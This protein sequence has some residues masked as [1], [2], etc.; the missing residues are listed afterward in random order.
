VFRA[1]WSTYDSDFIG[2]RSS[3]SLDLL[4][5]LLL[6]LAILEVLQKAFL[7]HVL[8]DRLRLRYEN[9]AYRIMKAKSIIY[10]LT[11]AS[12]GLP[13][14]KYEELPK[15]CESHPRNCENVAFRSSLIGCVSSLQ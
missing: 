1:Q 3:N 4:F 2:M 14:P 13:A 9:L 6:L 7:R 15:S 12:Y 11:M 8:R 5:L 10:R